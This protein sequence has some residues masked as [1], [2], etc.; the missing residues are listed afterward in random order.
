MTV[1]TGPNLPPQGT[2]GIFDPRNPTLVPN[3]DLSVA[4]A[5]GTVDHV[6]PASYFVSNP[7]GD[8]AATALFGGTVTTGDELT[9]V[10]TN[11]ILAGER[12]GSLQP[13]EIAHTYT[14]VSGDTVDTIA[15]AMADLF[16]DDPLA[17]AAG[18]R[19]D[20][21]GASVTFRWGGPGGNFAALTADLET[22]TIQV[23][24]THTAGDTLNV[25][26]T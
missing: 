25:L 1:R 24:G 11:N 14:T 15:E 9:L 3:F 20:T 2:P 26:F 8:A 18:L 22:D 12:Y 19:C 21:S 5:N 23:G 16:N 13:A 4:S 10:V 17:Q 6:S 7:R